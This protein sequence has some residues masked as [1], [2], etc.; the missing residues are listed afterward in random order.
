MFI[1]GNNYINYDNFCPFP[2]SYSAAFGHLCLFIYPTLLKKWGQNAIISE[3]IL[4]FA[5]SLVSPQGKSG[6]SYCMRKTFSNVCRCEP[7][8]SQT[9]NI[10]AGRRQP[11]RLRG[12]FLYTLIIYSSFWRGLTALSILCDVGNAKA[13]GSRMDRRADTYAFFYAIS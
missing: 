3:I 6:R 1:I 7:R 11:K 2:V 9:L 12:A 5:A 8:T 10:T 13:F 4:I